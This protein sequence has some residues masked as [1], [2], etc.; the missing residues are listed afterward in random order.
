MSSYALENAIERDDVAD[1]LRA[2]AG[3]PHLL[4]GG[5]H[6]ATDHSQLELA[7]LLLR[8]GADP[9]APEPWNCRTPLLEACDNRD[10][11]LVER[12]LDHGGDPHV[13][14]DYG[15][16][17]FD[18]SLGDA[19]L[20]C[21][22]IERGYTGS[23]AQQSSAFAT[24]FALSRFHE[25]LTETRREPLAPPTPPEGSHWPSPAPLRLAVY[26]DRH[27]PL[28]GELALRVVGPDGTTAFARTLDLAAPPAELPCSFDVAPTAAGTHT[29]EAAFTR[30]EGRASVL[31]FWVIEIENLAFFTHF[32]LHVRPWPPT[33]L[34]D[35]LSDP[36]CGAA[37]ADHLLAAVSRA[38]PPS[39]E[40][41]ELVAEWFLRTWPL[42]DQDPS[43][44]RT[45]LAIAVKLAHPRIIQLLERARPAMTDARD[46]ARVDAALR[47]LARATDRA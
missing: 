6:V 5:L 35:T 20:E 37:A 21:L 8:M 42:V 16:D 29:L 11:P 41:R 44:A 10:L 13:T 7:D 25:P 30:F 1:A 46:V 19:A 27:L 28:R 17:A 3:K 45:L 47:R 18:C 12:M 33:P 34:A 36:A 9:N 24:G 40:E 15:S 23:S 39:E 2:L 31:L 14:D 22:L 38:E 32:P 43:V 26:L 4:D